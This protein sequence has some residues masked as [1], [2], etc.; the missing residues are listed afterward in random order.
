MP[1]RAKNKSIRDN[2]I[3][4]VELDREVYFRCG[5]AASALGMSF[6]AFHERALMTALKQAGVE[7]GDLLHEQQCQ[8]AYD[9]RNV[10]PMR[11]EVRNPTF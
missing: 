2:T 7:V 8:R 11:Y 9:T 10:R 6:E 1:R 3:I 4:S 5:N